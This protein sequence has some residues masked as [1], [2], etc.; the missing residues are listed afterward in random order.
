MNRRAAIASVMAVALAMVGCGGS[1]P[2]N[3]QPSPGPTGGTPTTF[4]GTV[5]GTTSASSGSFSVTI[6]SSAA[7]SAVA[8]AT[9]ERLSNRPLSTSTASGTLTLA[10]GA[11]VALSGTYDSTTNAVNLTGGGFTLIGIVSTPTGLL[12]AFLGS[13]TGPNG[14]SGTFSSLSSDQGA[15]TP[16][17]GQL[18]PGGV[19][20]TAPV[21]FSFELSTTGAVY[22]E[23]AA[24]GVGLPAATFTGQITGAS[25]TLT[26]SQGNTGT[27]TIQNGLVTGGINLV[28]ASIGF[29]AVSCASVRSVT[30]TAVSVSG[31]VGLGGSAQFNATARFSDGTSQDVTSQSS[32]FSSDA[33]VASVTAGG[34]VTGVAAGTATIS[35]TYAGVTGQTTLMLGTT[36][37]PFTGV[38]TVNNTPTAETGACAGPG[39][40]PLNVPQSPIMTTVSSSGAFT[41]MPGGNST[42]AGTMNLSTGAWTFS[43]NGKCPSDT[44]GTVAGS[45]SCS[46]SKACSGTF[47]IASSPS[48]GVESGTVT[49][50]R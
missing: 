9:P 36:S 41:L 37:G 3:T 50:S 25:M 11:S 32:W 35:A 16:Y 24:I 23:Y 49:W 21:P 43:G 46:T 10:G 33:T 6:T 44:G 20:G 27:A 40:D 18:Y 39:A 1:S 38:W 31:A 28:V 48:G 34:V 22:G 5:V 42:L 47:A 7:S 13:F 45:G 12:H 19:W 29:Q 30:V 2:T 8:S 17:C 14:A 15:I 26:T 4:T